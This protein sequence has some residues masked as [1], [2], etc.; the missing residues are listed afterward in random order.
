MRTIPDNK[1]LLKPFDEAVDQKLIPALLNGR[2][3]NEHERKLF[4]LPLKLGGVGLSIVAEKSA[5]QYSNSRMMTKPL[6]QHVIEQ[7]NILNVNE[8]RLRES[9]NLIK[10][11]RDHENRE[12]LENLRLSKSD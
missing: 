12:V 5:R 1:V 2:H 8:T 3:L 6:V 7:K 11:V 10:T 9:I 4:S